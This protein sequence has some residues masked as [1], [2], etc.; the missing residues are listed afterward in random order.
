MRATR[1]LLGGILVVI[2]LL[3]LPGSRAKAQKTSPAP[4][5]ASHSTPAYLNP[6]LPLEERVNDLVSRMSLEEKASQMVNNARA[7]PR[8]GIPAYHWWSEGLHGDARAG[9]ATVFP[10]AI[11]MAASWNTNLLHRI[12]VA[13]SNEARAKY[14][15]DLRSGGTRGNRGLDFWAPNINIFRDPRWGRGQ[16][17]YGEDPFLTG[18]LA[19]AYVTGMQGDNPRYLRTIATPK[20]FDVHSGPEMIRHVFD[21]EVS[22]QA[23]EGTYLPAFREAVTAG[24]AGSVMCAYSALDGTPACASKLL[25]ETR[26]RKDWKFKGYVVSDCGAINDIW[27]N[28]HYAPDLVHAVADSIEAG[29][30]LSCGNEFLDVP[31]AVHAGLLS[32]ADVDRAVK[33]LFMARFR[34]GMFD[35]PSRVPYADTSQSEIDSPAHRQLALD[36]ARQSIVLLKNENAIL[37]LG[38]KVHSIAIVGPEADMLVT[39]EGNYHGTPENPVTPLAGMIQRFGKSDRLV[40]AQGSKL[41]GLQPVP[42]PA[43]AFAP[44]GATRAAGDDSIG[45]LKAE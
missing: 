8:L 20:H 21:A 43:S 23:L 16:E 38:P 36:A 45:G 32:E 15:W 34:L 2:L 7:I 17:T 12:A 18:R 25:L 29:T 9:R 13:I 27:A 41:V 42:V 31:A 6:N 5:R 3:A 22:E 33:R 28:H 4:A 14:E 40:Y 1:N 39:L 24:K 10:Q 19:V 37:P 35:P 30:D 26:L 44:T 11:A